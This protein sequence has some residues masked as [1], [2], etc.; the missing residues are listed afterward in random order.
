MRRVRGSVAQSSIEYLLLIAGAVLVAIIVL[1]LALTFSPFGQ[2]VFNTNLVEYEHIDLCSSR[3]ASCSF[4]LNWG[5]GLAQT[6]YGLYLQN[7][8]DWRTLVVTG[9][10]VSLVCGDRICEPAEIVEV[11]PKTS[12]ELPVGSNGPG[13]PNCTATTGAYNSCVPCDVA[14]ADCFEEANLGFCSGGACLNS[15]NFSGTPAAMITLPPGPN[16]LS[17]QKVAVRVTRINSS[18]VTGI[19][20]NFK[21]AQRGPNDS[22]QSTDVDSAISLAFHRSYFHAISEYQC[23][24]LA[25]PNLAVDGCSFGP[26]CLVQ[27]CL[28]IP[29]EPICQSGGVA[30]ACKHQNG[31]YSVLNAAAV[32]INPSPSIVYPLSI[33]EG[34]VFRADLPHFTSADSRFVDSLPSGFQFAVHEG[35]TFEYHPDDQGQCKDAATCAAACAALG[36]T[37]SGVQLFD[38]SAYSDGPS[39]CSDFY[40]ALSGPVISSVFTGMAGG[41]NANTSGFCSPFCYADYHFSQ[42]LTDMAFAGRD[43]VIGIRLPAGN[44]EMVSSYA[45]VFVPVLGGVYYAP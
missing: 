40:D 13:A 36:S 34:V 1:V 23:N 43:A 30:Y 10:E 38:L 29:D 27:S 39:I 15:V 20:Y 22:L 35:S 21:I 9:V 12:L 5:D 41:C 44:A 8:S 6:P 42:P 31:N 33:S 32:C 26:N 4:T 28:A 37:Y 19:R 7:D 16:P 45:S 2:Q 14:A 17:R 11:D 24:N 25:S 18:N 3:G